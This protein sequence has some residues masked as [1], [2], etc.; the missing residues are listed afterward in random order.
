[1]ANYYEIMQNLL[2]TYILIEIVEICL[3]KLRS[4]VPGLSRLNEFTWDLCV[5]VSRNWLYV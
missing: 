1:M 5:H 2:F 4:D 3:D